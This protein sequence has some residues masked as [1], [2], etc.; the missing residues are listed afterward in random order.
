MEASRA[1]QDDA[2]CDT[3]AK[4]VPFAGILVLLLFAFALAALLLYALVAVWPESKTVA[5]GTGAA[6]SQAPANNPIEFLGYRFKLSVDARFFTIVAIAGGLGGMVHTLRSLSWY[7]GNRHLKWS[8]VPF[9]VLLPVVGASCA[10]LFY[11]VL[12]AGLFSSSTAA[13]DANAYG[14]AAVGA[15]VGLFT[16]QAL[17]KLREVFSSILTS[18]PRGSDAVPPDVTNKPEAKTGDAAVLSQTAATFSG[19]VNPRGGDTTVKFVY[20]PSKSYGQV[21]ETTTVAADEEI[22]RVELQVDGLS[23]GTSYHFRIEAENAAGTT[24]G[25]DKTFTTKP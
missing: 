25:D 19:E 6:A 20:G 23:P 13:A 9:Y 22:H 7:I 11:L 5:Q 15:L 10:T 4:C 2:P 1:T 24:L 18:A 14:F 3:G 12:R 16:E 17:E 8:W 21:T